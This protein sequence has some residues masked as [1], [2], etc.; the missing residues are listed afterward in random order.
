MG[1][2]SAAHLDIFS[3]S[4]S[5]DTGGKINLNTAPAPVLR[6]LAGGITL[7]KDPAM[8]PSSSL[9]IPKTM[10]EAFVQGVMRYRSIYPFLSSSQLAFIATDH[11]VTNGANHWTNTWPKNAVFGNTNTTISLTNAP[12]N[13]LGTSASLGGVT[14]WN[15]QAAEEW[16]SKIYNL[17]TVQSWN[18][19]VYVVAQLVNTNGLPTGP[20]MRKY[21]LMYIRY[22]SDFPAIS[23]GPYTSF[24]SAY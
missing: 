7:T 23:A 19:R 13:T 22:N 12:G 6:A 9:A 8:L 3:L 5:F 2:S 1:W 18:Y 16:F 14:A 15:D 21:S 11:G 4:D 24:E 20:S 10:T 17:S